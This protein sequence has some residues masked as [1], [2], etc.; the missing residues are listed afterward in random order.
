MVNDSTKTETGD[1][2]GPGYFVNFVENNKQLETHVKL[3]ITSG[4]PGKGGCRYSVYE[5]NNLLICQLPCPP[6]DPA[7][8]S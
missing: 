3:Y 5:A 6:T 4:E 7:S 2:K 8:P 1:G